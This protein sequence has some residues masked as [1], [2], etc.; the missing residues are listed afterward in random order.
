MSLTST[1]LKYLV[2]KV[3]LY[4]QAIREGA[5][6]VVAVG[7]DGTLHE[8][9]ILVLSLRS[10]NIVILLIVKRKRQMCILAISFPYIHQNVH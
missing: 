7:G 9:N 1:N 3:Q 5:D 6:A 8:V 10:S 2:V 4:C